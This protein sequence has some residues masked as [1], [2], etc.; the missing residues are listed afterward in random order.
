MEIKITGRHF[1]VSDKLKELTTKKVRKLGKYFPRLQQIE[2]LLSQEK[3]RYQT[4]ILI[5]ADHFTVEGQAES[6]DLQ[7]CL[8]DA[9]SKV[10]RRLR[11][12]KEKL[13]DKK[14]IRKPILE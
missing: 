12:H 11:R 1:D 4:E 5:T 2:V 7:S 3:F 8:D 9:V 6:D 13:I 10:E 14:H